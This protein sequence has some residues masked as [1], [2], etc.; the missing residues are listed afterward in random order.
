MLSIEC[1]RVAKWPQTQSAYT[2]LIHVLVLIGL[3][4]G[5]VNTALSRH[6]IDASSSGVMVNV[7]NDLANL[8][9]TAM[10]WKPWGKPD[11][12]V[13]L[14]LAAARADAVLLV[15]SYRGRIPSMARNRLADGSVASRALHDKPLAGVGRSSGCYSGIWSRRVEDA[16]GGLG[17][18]IEPLTVPALR[19]VITQ[20]ADEVHGGDAAATISLP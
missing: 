20:L 5:P 6:A 9:D 16:R 14:C 11:A 15:T 2:D 12:V 10:P 7:F 13:E 3:P 8:P 19:D 17:R 4:A 18:R 1:G